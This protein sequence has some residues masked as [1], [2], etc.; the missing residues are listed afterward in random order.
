MNFHFQKQKFFIKKIYHDSS[1]TKVEVFLFGPEID[2][3]TVDFVKSRL[4]K[5]G[6]QNVDL[7]IKQAF[8]KDSKNNFSNI[9]PG[10]IEDLYKRNEEIIAS[11]EK[12]IKFLEDKLSHYLE[13][14]YPVQDIAKE[15]KI[16]F[17]DILELSI[18]KSLIMNLTED[19]IDTAIIA[20]A[21]FKNPPK[22]LERNKF[23]SWLKERIKAKELKLI[24]K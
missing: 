24:V 14:Q 21:R 7:N 23:Y 15:A 5:Y 22:T 19:K 2:N 17:K 8:V 12:Q 6:L 4:P 16:I 3:E 9:G 18:Y 11:K 1:K 13:N 20:Y 10:I